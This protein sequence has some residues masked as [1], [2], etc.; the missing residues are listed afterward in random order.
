[1]YSKNMKLVCASLV[2]SIYGV[3]HPQVLPFCIQAG[4]PVRTVSCRS[5]TSLSL[6][7]IVTTI[8]CVL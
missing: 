4:A 2:T 5:Q 3:S 6:F 1:M 8:C 7:E